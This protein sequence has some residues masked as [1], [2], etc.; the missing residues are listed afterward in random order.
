MRPKLSIRDEV[1]QL[2]EKK[3]QYQ[4]PKTGAWQLPLQEPLFSEF[5][6]YESLQNL[7]EQLNGV[8]SKLNNYGVQEWSTHTNRRDP[9]GEISWRLKNETKAEFV[10]VAWCK[11]FECLHRYPLVKQ[12]Q[13]NTLHLC[14]AP[15]AFIAALNH[16]LHSVYKHDEVK[17]RW[18]STTLNPYYEGNAL[19]EMITDDR[20]IFHTLDNW[21]FHKDL[22]G[23]LL[24]VDNIEH[25][26]KRCAEDL[27]D[28][29]HLITADGSIDCSAQPD[30]QEELVARLFVAEI[31]SA[32]NILKDG[33]NFVIK[34]FTLFEACSV[35]LIYLLNC[36]FRAVHI[37]KPATSKRG[38]SEVYVICM[39]YQKQTPGLPRILQAM[40][41]KLAQSSDTMV[42]PLFSKAQIP[43]DFVMQHEIGCR[44]Y[45]KLQQEAIEG[46]IYAYE[47]KDRYYLRHLHQLRGVVSSMYYNR[48]KVRPL[49][50][51][52]CIVKQEDINQA[53][54]Y[55]VPV[56]GGSYT[57][58]ENLRQGD[59]LKQIY[60]LRREFNQLEK[61]PTGKSSYKHKQHRVGS[62]QMQL[63]KG[64]AVQELQSS[65]FASEPIL[66]LRL[67][68][69][70]IFELD[71]L[72]QTAPK[73]LFFDG[74]NNSKTLDYAPSSE[75]NESTFHVVQ[76]RFFVTLVES[77]L[78][79]RPAKIVFQNF[80]FLT[81]YAASVLLFLAEII[82][83]HTEFDQ[84]ITLSGCHKNND[85]TEQLQQL[86]KFL[87]DDLG[88][89]DEAIHSVLHLR[90][91][92]KNA[93]SNALILHNNSI[94]LEC[95]RRM[96]GED[97]F[98]RRMSVEQTQIVQDIKET[99]TIVC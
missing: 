65:L 97:S 56:Y 16:Y 86:Q 91:L 19:N 26:T 7:K 46:S 37:Y 43:S 79:A 20:F 61:C 85:A 49:A 11:F 24:N 8:K 12:P 88:D 5:Y 89:A 2:F 44:L 82:Y 9:S 38:N 54:G 87:S 92:Q 14:E 84:H 93:F 81:H 62:L 27:L 71:P 78:A 1:E 73:C 6:Q 41:V 45:L 96:L 98:P 47:T 94:L 55:S 70:D 42:L 32:L 66:L 52:L 33:G 13:L 31:I 34:M 22:T 40:R 28:E 99:T 15:G 4:K 80:T 23:N 29:V 75:G 76:R 3:F 48:Y 60:C 74:S 36:I 50:D 39:D 25:M 77:L 72:W 17:W 63:S 83:E 30:C 69:L 21:L 10:T 51:E 67:R 90:E 64:A 18:R 57:E 95:F 59:L 35:S 58:R 53:L 68:I